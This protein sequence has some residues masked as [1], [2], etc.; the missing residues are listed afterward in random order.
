[1]QKGFGIA[2]L[3]IAILAMFTPFIGTW[4]TIVVAVLAVAAYGP[5][6]GLGIASLL[7]NVAHIMFFSPLLW[8]TQGAV[9]LGAEASGEEVL[10]MPWVL[11]GVQ[12]VAFAALLLFNRLFASKREAPALSAAL[13]E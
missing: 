12:V 9:V 1:M 2:A 7:I 3:V 11:I 5:G 10:F 4:L 13:E 8:A 6:T